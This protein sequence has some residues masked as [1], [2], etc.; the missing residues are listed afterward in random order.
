MSAPR[1]PHEW[2][3]KLGWNVSLII[4]GL[5]LGFF[6]AAQWNI[7]PDDSSLPT[8]RTR[9]DLAVTIRHLEQEQESLKQ[10]IER[11][12]RALEQQQQQAATNTRLLTGLTEELEVQRA[13]AG[14]YP[15]NGPGIRVILADSDRETIPPGSDANLFIIHEYDLRDTVNVLW[16]ANA[17]AIAI[18]GERMVGTTSIYC[19]GST[20]LVNDTRLSP[21]Y[22]I[23]VI[24]DP[25]SLEKALSG[26]PYLQDLRARAKSYG[27]QF[28]I[29][30]E[31]EIT[32]PAYRGSFAIRHA[33]PGS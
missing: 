16:T 24:G 5:I 10:E 3:R 22:V 21:P 1:A 32:I 13:A 29:V 4:A 17:E 19:V 2:R 11:L 26:T 30:R 25:G 31:K 9:E 14:L 33:R 15:L 6:F 23:E 20:I 8:L 28:R 7:A 12:R 18:N 27:L